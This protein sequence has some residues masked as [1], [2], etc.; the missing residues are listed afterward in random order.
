MAQ[1]IQWELTTM[2]TLNT[3]YVVV[4]CFEKARLMDFIIH[5][6]GFNEEIAKEFVQN[7]RSDEEIAIIRGLQVSFSPNT[8]VI[9]T[10]LP[11]IGEKWFKIKPSHCK[12]LFEQGNESYKGTKQGFQRIDLPAPWHEVIVHV[13]TYFTYEGRT[14]YPF[15]Q[16]F[17]ILAHL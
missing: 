17:R 14:T 10:R 5:L 16:H 11:H 12:K 3:C 13:I 9:A 1:G 6:D 15:S 4:Q 7:Y 2:A 8:I